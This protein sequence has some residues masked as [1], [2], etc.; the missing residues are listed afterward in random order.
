MKLSSFLALAFLVC[1]FV[2]IASAQDK[3]PVVNQRE[4]NQQA[5][6]A[7]GVK[8]GQLTPAETRRLERQEGRIKAHELSAKSDGKVTKAERRSLNRQLNRESRRIHR[9]KHNNKTAG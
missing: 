3:T 7:A 4:R 1:M 5:R 6:I 8:S 9:L 2:G